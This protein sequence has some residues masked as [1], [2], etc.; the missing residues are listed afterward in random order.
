MSRRQGTESRSQLGC[1]VSWPS[2]AAHHSR[3]GQGTGSA[4]GGWKYC[5][6]GRLSFQRAFQTAAAHAWPW[7]Q[8][9]S[10]LPGWYRGWRR[11]LSSKQRR[12]SESLRHY[13][14]PSPAHSTKEGGGQPPGVW[15]PAAVKFG[16]RM[17][18][19]PGRVLGLEPRSHPP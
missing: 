6:K 11:D 10:R 14:Q 5:G 9:W 7:R 8:A 17:L 16:P 18:R 4:S 3:A 13:P 15:A 19:V 12:P 2:H 1:Q